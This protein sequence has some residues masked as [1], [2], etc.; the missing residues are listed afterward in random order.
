MND[1]ANNL[2]SPHRVPRLRSLAAAALLLGSASLTGTAEASTTPDDAV[3]A[4]TRFTDTYERE[5]IRVEIDLT[6]FGDGEQLQEGVDASFDFKITDTLTGQPM[7]GAYPAA[8]MDLRLGEEN[9][10]DDAA[11]CQDKLK[12][13]LSGSLMSQPELDLNVYYVLV[14]NKEA[15]ISVVDPLF[16]FGGSKLLDMVRLPSPAQDWVL[17]KDQR[18]LFVSMPEAKAVAVIRTA[19]WRVLEKIAVA[20][21][22]RRLAMQPDGRYLW[23]GVDNAPASDSAEAKDST[24][25]SGVTVL[26]TES[27]EVVAHVATGDGHHEIAFDA[28]SRY[29]FVTNELG[30]GL[31]VIDVAQ[32]TK[33]R[34]IA[35]GAGPAAI[36]YSPAAQAVYVANRGAGTVTAID[37]TTLETRANIEVEPG[38][39]FLRFAPDGRT[40]AVANAE[41][42]YLHVIDAASNRLVKSGEV[43][44]AP[45]QVTFSETLAYVRHRGSEIVLMITLDNLADERSPLSVTDFPGGQE[46]PGLTSLPSLADGIVQAPGSNAVLVANPGDKMIYFYKEG[47]AAPMGSFKTY[48]R[49]PR[50]VMVLD[51]SLEERRP[52]TYSTEARLRRPGTYDLVFFMDSPRVVHCFEVE[53]GANQAVAAR[54]LAR[55][56]VDIEPQLGSPAM[57]SGQ[58]SSLRFEIRD[59]RTGELATGVEDVMV[60]AVQAPGVWHVRRAA[61][62]VEPG[63]YESEIT[64]PAGGVY[65]LTVY[66][67]SLGLSK[68]DSP[69]LVVEAGPAPGDAKAAATTD[70]ST[71]DTETAGR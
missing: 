59:G 60:Q 37:T 15:S 1:N 71:E 24:E 33:V 17:S 23:I 52:G 30:G 35:T 55:V 43:E 45:D 69:F 48:S 53:V 9:G 44:H 19:D 65:Y 67:S 42:S 22:P 40:A 8:W 51:R 34:D 10:S 29:A 63:I 11:A 31:S 32:H 5:G 50:A 18:T 58:P 7:S 49:E 27:R 20:G 12:S 14:M 36:D 28:D 54:R 62:E 46:P 16:G 57:V 38:I 2:F 61:R 68:K 41:T 56:P 39:H 47:M 70:P 6:P 64:A 26:D 66:S 21:A 3:A 13:F 25:Q 4:N